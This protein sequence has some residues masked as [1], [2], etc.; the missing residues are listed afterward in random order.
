MAE[1]FAQTAAASVAG[2]D[3]LLAETHAPT[4]AFSWAAATHGVLVITA[5][6]HNLAVI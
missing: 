5:S 1:A 4:P 3:V 2:F 6:H